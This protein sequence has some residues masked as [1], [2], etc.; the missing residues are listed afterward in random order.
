MNWFNKKQLIDLLKTSSK[1]IASQKN[2]IK[3]SQSSVNEGNSYDW[4]NQMGTYVSFGDVNRYVMD[5]YTVKV[6]LSKTDRN[7][8]ISLMTTHSY[9]GTVQ[10]SVFWIF[11][12]DEEDLA[13]KAYKKL[14][15]SVEETIKT[16]VAEQKP[17]S[18][19]YPTLR[20][21]TQ[22]VG[23]RHLVKTNIPVVNY[24]YDINYSKDW[25]QN[26]YGPRYPTYKEINFDQYLN[27]GIY[28][29]DGHAPTGKFAL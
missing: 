25:D 9:L 23:D 28:S 3:T 12:F 6:Y 5:S 17:T 29:K 24:S 27:S 21:K 11:D 2:I 1:I 20:E 19:F 22:T 18:L 26:I 4:K 15:N 16:F 13:I 7:I 14:N 8:T 10:Y